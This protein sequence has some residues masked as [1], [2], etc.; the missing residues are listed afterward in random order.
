MRNL[1]FLLV[2]LSFCSQAF[3]QTVVA[4]DYPVYMMTQTNTGRPEPATIYRTVTTF[5]GSA[6]APAGKANATGTVAGGET[7]T[8][9]ELQFF[10][11][12]SPANEKTPGQLHLNYRLPIIVIR[13]TK[14]SDEGHKK[15]TYLRGQFT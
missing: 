10:N 12:G 3:S 11:P 9:T 1:L 7:I 8:Q 14:N 5:A 13:V 2:F 15:T 4:T 6:A